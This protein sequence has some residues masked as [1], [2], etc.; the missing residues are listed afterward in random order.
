MWI[1][2]NVNRL[3]FVALVCLFEFS[4]CCCFLMVSLGKF[5]V[6]IVLL[7]FVCLCIDCYG[8]VICTLFSWLVSVY[9]VLAVSFMFWVVGW[10]VVLDG[11]CCLFC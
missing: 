10:N 4:Y 9:S 2:R 6:L 5:G 1:V 8:L 3:I 7:A 11:C